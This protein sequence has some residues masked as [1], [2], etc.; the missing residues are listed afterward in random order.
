MH[1]SDWWRLG[2]G[3]PDQRLFPSW[4]PAPSSYGTPGLIR[5]ISWV[6]PVGLPEKGV[7]ACTVCHQDIG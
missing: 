2:A 7:E 3:D 4:L 1:R 5:K 6:L